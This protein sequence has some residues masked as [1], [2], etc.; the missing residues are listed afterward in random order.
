MANQNY[1]HLI[2]DTIQASGQDIS[3][4]NKL[5][6]LKGTPI[7]EFPNVAPDGIVKETAITSETL[8]VVTFT[9]AAATPAFSTVYSLAITIQNPG[10]QGADPDVIYKVIQITTPATGTLT[11]T[12]VTTQFKTAIN[13]ALGTYVLAT[14]TATLIVTALAGYPI[15]NGGWVQNPDASTVVQTTLGVAKRGTVAAMALLGAAANTPQTIWLSGTANTF[16]GTAYTLYSNKS[17]NNVGIQNSIRQNQLTNVC[18]WVNEGAT[19]YSTFITD[20]D[21]M[22]LSKDVTTGGVQTTNYKA[23][24]AHE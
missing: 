6:S 9:V 19:N 14:G 15:V 21:G 12:T 7:W 18:I 20:M 8:G 1:K 24:E 16:A 2:L 23:V 10:A 4:V 3:V 11:P 22:L 17:Y 5:F 13:A